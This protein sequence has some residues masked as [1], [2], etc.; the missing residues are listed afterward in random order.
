MRRKEKTKS[1][2][3]IALYK[4]IRIMDADPNQDLNKKNSTGTI[5]IPEY[6]QI[7]QTTHAYFLRWLHRVSSTTSVEEDLPLDG[8]ET[9]FE[10]H[11]PLLGV[12][13]G[14]LQVSVQQLKLYLH[15]IRTVSQ[16]ISSE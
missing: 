11:L 16:N 7:S 8:L 4:F 1:N 13:P 12:V 10:L 6:V 5:Y 2:L 14:R 9:S 15:H 3:V